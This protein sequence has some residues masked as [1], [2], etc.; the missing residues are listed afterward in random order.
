MP[1]EPSLPVHT[2]EGRDGTRLAFREVGDG[3]PLVLLH[4]FVSNATTNWIR[5]GHAAALAARGHRVVMPDLRGHGDSAHPHDPASYPPDV[6]AD[7]AAALV[8]QLGLEGYDLG[9]YSLGGRTVLR[10]LVRGARPR[11]AVVAGMGLDHV[12]DTGPGNDRFREVLARLGS[13]ERG[14]P[15]WMVEQFLRSNDGDPEALVRVLDSA[16]DTAEVELALLDTPTLVA[17]GED[18][19]EHASAERLAAVLPHARFVVLPGNHMSAATK[20]ALAV[21][22]GDFL[23]ADEPV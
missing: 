1:A 16:V 4:G 11:R 23:G 3:P 7:D 18:D 5:F 17:V 20:P 21:A 10:M 15:G 8:E 12:V 14:D 2:Y 13:F 6:L 19:V 9:G 22:I